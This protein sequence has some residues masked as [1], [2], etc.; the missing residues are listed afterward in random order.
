MQIEKIQ[1]SALVHQQ[2]LD[3]ILNPAILDRS[4]TLVDPRHCK[5]KTTLSIIMK[6]QVF[7]L[8]VGSLRSFNSIFKI[9]TL[10][11]MYYRGIIDQPS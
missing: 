4:L 1:F 3:P 10:T 5:M 11:C 7:L 8:D 6:F 2:I 9:D